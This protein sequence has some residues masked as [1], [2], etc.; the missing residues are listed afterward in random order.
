MRNYHKVPKNSNPILWDKEKFSELWADYS[1]RELAQMLQ[2]DHKA[3]TNA[4][5]RFNLKGLKDTGFKH[6]N[7]RLVN[8]RTRPFGTKILTP[9][10]Y[11]IIR[12]VNGWEREHRLIVE[13]DLGRKL[14]SSEHIHHKNGIK[15]DNRLENLELISRANHVLYDEL[16]SNCGLRKEIRLLRWQIKQLTEAHTLFDKGRQVS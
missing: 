5:K 16:C 2:I 14:L 12:T 13:Q 3:I 11:V 6:S 1:I 10:G 8:K 9:D 15:T 7:I 4:V